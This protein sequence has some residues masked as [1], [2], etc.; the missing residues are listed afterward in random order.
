[1]VVRKLPAAPRRR[2]FTDEHARHI[3]KQVADWIADGVI[4]PSQAWIAYNPVLVPKSNGKI[5]VCVNY[6]PLNDCIE[7]IAW[8]LPK[9]QD[10]RFRLR[11]GG[12][13]KFFAKIDLASAFHE[14]DI[15]PHQR[16]LT[17]FWAGTRKYQFK[18]MSF[19]L[20]PAPKQYQRFIEYVLANI[21]NLFVYI[22]DILLLAT[23]KKKLAKLID[24]VRSRL[25]QAKLPINEEKSVYFRTHVVF[26]G[27]QVSASGLT[28][29]PK[30][31]ELFLRSKPTNQKELQSLLGFANC[32]KSYT[33]EFAVRTKPL[34]SETGT[35]FNWNPECDK[36]YDWVITLAERT[37]EN[38]HATPGVPLQLYTDASGWGTGAVLMQE[39]RVIAVDSKSFSETEMKYSTT[40]REHLGLV[41]AVLSFRL[42]IGGEQVML[43]TD[44]TSLCNRSEKCLT[45]KQWRWKMILQEWATGA[46]YIRGAD[47]P[48]DWPSRLQHK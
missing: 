15:A 33:P 27:H 19:G 38:A 2:V 12:G 13:G 14:I 8:Q 3:E 41:R 29:G 4:E 28:A 30:V 43:H 39:G 7:D 1:M 35:R 26:L 47:N 20:K 9:V 45:A 31:K 22:D 10:L 32:F 24:V 18:K 11:E 6:K 25:G 16:E 37:V 21:H 44:H 36:A 34:Y 48:A 23:T 42:F 17:A 5:R 40:D 46:Q